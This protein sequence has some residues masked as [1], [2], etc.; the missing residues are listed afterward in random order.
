MRLCPDGVS[1]RT[2]QTRRTMGKTT[3]PRSFDGLRVLIAGGGVAGLETMLA[4]RDLAGN[5]VDI[6]LL[7]PEHHFWYRPLAVGEPFDAAEV[8]RFELQAV[9]AAVG[10]TFTPASVAIVDPV[11]HRV[12]TSHGTEITYDVLVI[13]CGTRALPALDAA[14]TFR[15]PSDVDRF[16]ALLA[17]LDEGKVKRIVFALPRRAGWS[18]PLYE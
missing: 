13:A 9:A 3:R 2:T 5:L 18:L 15:G 10:A 11:G 14:L 1:A 8:R 4:L 7:S 12:L 6:E 17:E 16:R